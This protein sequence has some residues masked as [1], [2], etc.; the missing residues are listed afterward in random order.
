VAIPKEDLEQLLEWK[1]GVD[2][3]YR[4]RIDKEVFG[5]KYD[6][7]Q[8]IRKKA[9]IKRRMEK[10]ADLKIDRLVK[11]GKLKWTRKK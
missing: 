11:E 6:K 1:S 9:A 10:Y 5:E 7:I 2:A 3:D 4:D 8:E